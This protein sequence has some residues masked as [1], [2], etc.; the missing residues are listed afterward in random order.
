MIL[1]PYPSWI[2]FETTTLCTSKCITCPSRLLQGVR[3]SLMETPLVEK[4]IG[5]MA[6]HRDEVQTIIPFN[7]GEPLIDSRIFDFMY[8]ISDQIG[9]SKIH[10]STNASLLV[11]NEKMNLLIRAMELNQ[12]KQLVFS[13]DGKEHF[14]EV[15]VGLNYSVIVQNILNFVGRL[16]HANNVSVHMTV[17][18][19][20]I[21]DLNDFCTFWENKG[22]RA[23]FMACDGRVGHGLSSS[24]P[25]PC[26]LILWSNIYILSDGTVVP[27]CCD[28]DAKHP[29]GNFNDNTISEI[30]HGENYQE[31]RRMH[32]E[33]RKSDS[34]LCSQCQAHY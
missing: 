32:M 20:N 22:I 5:D 25:L 21:S 15:R 4:L 34:P 24:S 1:Q 14:D 12:I 9:L 6:E 30:W 29:L 18:P 2:Q 17:C 11:S 31:L 19:E 10:F 26:S 27:C 7:S 23:T 3:D 33:I 8:K 16:S 28:F 13:V